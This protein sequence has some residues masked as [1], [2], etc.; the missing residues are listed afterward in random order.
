MNENGPWNS[1]SFYSSSWS[2]IVGPYNFEINTAWNKPKII[3][4]ELIDKNFP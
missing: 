3:T 1:K 4:H 2:V